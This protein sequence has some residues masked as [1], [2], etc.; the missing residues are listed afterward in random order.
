MADPN[1]CQYWS[2]LEPAVCSHWDDTVPMCTYAG[3]DGELAEYAPF[4]NLLGTQ[5]LCNQYDGEGT[6]SRCILPDISR[7]V[8]DRGSQDAS[9]WVTLPQRDVNGEITEAADFS[10]ITKYGTDHCVPGEGD[11]TS[12]E[13]SA[14][15]PYHLG[16]ST[17]QPDDKDSTLGYDQDGYTTGSGLTF[18]LPLGYEVFNYRAMLS[19]CYWWNG[20]YETFSVDPDDGQVREITFKCNHPDQGYVTSFEEFR[21][22][23]VERQYVPPCNG[24]KPEC[25]YYTGICWKYCI[26]DKMRQGDKVLAEQILELRYYIRKNKWNDLKFNRAFKNAKIYAWA[27]PDKMRYQYNP[28]N[29]MGQIWWDIG[30]FKTEITDFETFE[31]S[32]QGERLTT[33][34]R[35]EDGKEDYPTLVEALK[36]LPLAPIIRNKFYTDDENRKV[37][38]VASLEHESVLIFGDTFYQSPTY[39]I[40]LSD[41]DLLFFREEFRTLL[42]KQ[43]GS[44]N[45]DDLIQAVNDGTAEFEVEEHYYES[46]LE[47]EAAY[48]KSTT[49]TFEDFQ[50]RLDGYIQRL[51]KYRPDKIYESEVSQTSYMF[52][53]DVPAVWGENVIIVL[54]KGSGQWEFDLINFYKIFCGGV[55][56]Q[57]SFELR[58]ESGKEIGYLPAYERNFGG[59][60]NKNAYIRFNFASYGNE[61]GD[62]ADAAYVYNDYATQIPGIT[63]A[64]LPDTYHLGYTLYKV[65]LPASDTFIDKEYIRFF[66]NAGY[67]LVDIPDNDNLSCVFR[68]WEIKG[69]FYV[70]VTQTDGTEK[71]VEMEVVEKCTDRLEVNQMIIK[72]KN[73]QEFSMPCDLYIFFEDGLYYYEKRSFG[74]V[75]V[76]DY[77]IVTESFIGDDETVVYVDSGNLSSAYNSY[78][79]TEFGRYT[80]LISVVYRGRNT[81]KIKGVTRTKMLTWVRQPYCRDVEIF[82]KWVSDYQHFTLQPER[83]C[84]GKTS[85][86]GDIELRTRSYTP[87]CGDHDLSFLTNKGPMWYPYDSCDQ[88]AVYPIDQLTSRVTLLTNRVMEVFEPDEEGIIQHGSWDLRMLGPQTRFGEVCDSH[89]SLWEC[90]CDWSY[91]NDEKVGENRFAGRGKYRG[92]LDGEAKIKATRFGGIMPRFGNV[93]RD[94]LRSYRSIDNAFYYI[95]NVDGTYYRRQKWMPLYYFYTNADLTADLGGSYAYDLYSKDLTSPFVHPMGLYLANSQIEGVTIAEYLDVDSNGNPNRYYFEDV[96]ETHKTPVSIVYPY[97]TNLQFQGSNQLIT[98][99]TYKDHPSDATKSIQWAWQEIWKSLERDT[100][101]IDIMTGSDTYGFDSGEYNATGSLETSDETAVE[102]FDLT[103]SRPYRIGSSNEYAGPHLF[104]DVEYPPYKYDAKIGEHRLTLEETSGGLYKII[105]TAP[106]R[107]A[108]GEY[109]DKKFSLKIVAPDGSEGP[110]RTFDIDG[111]W[112]PDADNNIY[113]DLYTTCTTDPWVTDVTLFGPGYDDKSESQAETDDRV[114]VTYDEFGSEVR[115]YY[116]RGLN[117]SLDTDKFIYLPRQKM[118]LGSGEYQVKFSKTPTYF[119][120]EDNPYAGIEPD[121]PYPTEHCWEIGYRAEDEEVDFEFELNTKA[122]ID[123]II[124]ICKFGSEVIGQDED[125]EPNAW[126]LFHLPAIELAHSDLGIIYTTLFSTPDMSLA[127]N[128][129]ALTEEK[130]IIDYN[131]SA[132]DLLD[133]HSKWRLR[134]RVKPTVLEEENAGIDEYFEDVGEGEVSSE[135]VVYIKCIYLYDTQFVGAEESIDVW[136]R[137]YNI[138]YG[139]HG[140]FPPHGYE[141]NTILNPLA[142]SIPEYSTVYQRDTV[143]GVVGVPNSAGQLETMNKIRGRIMLECHEDEEPLNVTSVYDMENEQ[144]KIHDAIAVKEGVTTCTFKAVAP[145]GFVDK[146]ASAKATYPELWT[147]TFVNTYILPLAEVTQYSPYNPE[148]FYWDWDYSDFHWEPRCAGSTSGIFS[149][150]PREVFEYVLRSAFN[151]DELFYPR[152]AIVVYYETIGSLLINPL[153]YLYGEF[154]TAEALAERGSQAG[155]TYPGPVDPY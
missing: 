23:D 111:N 69:S 118:Q 91:C 53:I 10:K 126:R 75:P 132:D 45:P 140:D 58:G 12:V 34:N 117:V 93:V 77:E 18:R 99:Y 102:E 56:A 32:A 85:L 113:Y 59:D 128:E 100:T 94:F 40:N 98:W 129:D 9:K 137:L 80:L 20:A 101:E 95:Q 31:V 143:N 14:F 63:P 72:P 55:I 17:I 25:Q 148:G 15:S 116:Q 47:I 120:D 22:D 44:D 123:K 8:I 139:S 74:E 134:I 38:E 146:L 6:Q 108:S 70:A 30:A 78:T 138:S 86:K 35:A 153:Q 54:N 51:L 104:L 46:M 4:C 48:S 24:C 71:N 84:Y 76:G 1:V 119:T 43:T 107:E 60:I 141:G 33:G 124:L 92:G 90:T 89:A 79:L 142:P 64:Y 152:W 36:E 50:E 28:N 87:G 133:T 57:T 131:M 73:L 65:K 125:N 127:T 82:Y 112:D 41:P 19:K 155:N 16:F 122:A 52:S 110:Y 67:A 103:V 39:A 7:H 136:E 62:S 96:F 2:P 11:G 145:P 130:V 37:F 27:G 13:C 115:T 81:G 144:K 97:P 3:P 147:L 66:G 49:T 83:V 150:G 61:L 68:D 5:S 42:T 149:V 154:A 26:D 106:E 105:L 21:Y 114:I 29:P 151:P 121:E 109:D 135:Q 88:D